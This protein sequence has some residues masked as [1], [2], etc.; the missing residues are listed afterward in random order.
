MPSPFSLPMHTLRIAGK[1]AL[2]LIAWFAC[3][4]LTRYLLLY[5]GTEVAYGD[6]RELRAIAVMVI[7]TLVVLARMTVTIG[8]LYSLRRALWEVRARAGDGVREERFFRTLDRA[9]PA[10]AVL[11]LAWNFIKDDAVEFQQLDML[12]HFFDLME[13]SWFGEE[14][15]VGRAFEMD[16]RVSLVAMGV[17]FL[18]KTLFAKLVEKGRKGLYGFAA[19]FSEFA[20]VFY[21]INAVV[22]FGDA[23]S[24]WAERRAVVAGAKGTLESTK[25]TVPVWDAFTEWFAEFWPLFVDAVAL[26]LVWL[27]VA[28][29]VFGVFSDD[30]RVLVRGTRLEKGVDKLESSHEL[31]RKSFEFVTSGFTDRWLPLANSVRMIVKGGA[32]LFGMMC[33]CWVVINVSFRYLDRVVRTLIGSEQEWAWMYLSG[34]VNF[35][36]DLLVTMLTMALIAATYDLA[37]TRARLRGESLNAA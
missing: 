16:W 22:A 12:H 21:G 30:A 13:A 27:T 23:R 31:D 26:P 4:E 7:M 10:F 1:C 6:F 19:A 5:A 15:Q 24:A 3:G 35:V 11:Y 25:E 28:M 14:S 37:A 2:P 9:A 18:L 36:R 32:P 20:F 17:M 33:L 8:M 29:I 34:P